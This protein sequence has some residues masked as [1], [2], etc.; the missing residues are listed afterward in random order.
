MEG[1]YRDFFLLYFAEDDLLDAEVQWCWPGADRNNI[2]QIIEQQ[3][4]HWLDA[5]RKTDRR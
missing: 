4:R 3:F 5:N 1:E 2:D